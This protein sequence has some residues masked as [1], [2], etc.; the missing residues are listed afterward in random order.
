M[1]EVC[2]NKFHDLSSSITCFLKTTFW[3]QTARIISKNSF[4]WKMLLMKISHEICFCTLLSYLVVMANVLQIKWYLFIRFGRS[5]NTFWRF[6]LQKRKSFH[7]IIKFFILLKN[8]GST[9]APKSQAVNSDWT[10]KLT[11]K[12]KKLIFFQVKAEM[13]LFSILMSGGH[14]GGHLDVYS[15]LKLRVNSVKIR[16]SAKS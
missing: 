4:F 6:L 5:F 10:K 9:V 14:L 3:R 12:D 11:K 1:T 7:K 15:I 2:K 13:F 16:K 8:G